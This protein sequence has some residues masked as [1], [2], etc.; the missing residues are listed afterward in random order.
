[1]TERI[2][3][4]AKCSKI[5]EGAEIRYTESDEQC[6]ASQL[7]HAGCCRMVFLPVVL[8]TQCHQA[9]EKTEKGYTRP[10]VTSVITPPKAVDPTDKGIA[11]QDCTKEKTGDEPSEPDSSPVL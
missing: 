9:E 10:F 1:M 8:E 4:Y 6:L 5:I 3:R 11:V 2:E 7:F